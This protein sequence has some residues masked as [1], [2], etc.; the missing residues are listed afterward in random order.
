M[1]YHV[2]FCKNDCFVGITGCIS[3]F[4]TVSKRKSVNVSK[5]V[6]EV[7]VW[8]YGQSSCLSPKGGPVQR[9]METTR[10]ENGLVCNK[11]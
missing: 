8:C 1:E 7:G 9:K 3:T 11:I 10:V 4:S 5:R 6:E 2:L